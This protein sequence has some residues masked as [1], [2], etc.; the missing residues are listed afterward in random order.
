MFPSTKFLPNQTQGL[1][2]IFF[3]SDGAQPQL[4]PA[5]LLSSCPG[6]PSRPWD[7]FALWNWRD[8]STQ[9]GAE[10]GTA[11]PGGSWRVYP[12]IQHLFI[13]I[14]QAWNTFLL[15]VTANLNFA[16]E[17]HP[18]LCVWPPSA[19]SNA[20]NSLSHQ[21][22]ENFNF[23]SWLGDCEEQQ[24]ISCSWSYG[25]MELPCSSSITFI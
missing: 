15:S 20:E 3:S 23:I 14:P 13:S 18:W 22:W 17:M 19:I 21:T 10:G 8:N 9:T 6:S 1:W 5:L 24:G 7:V 16:G 11:L 4:L 12:R 25:K 2:L